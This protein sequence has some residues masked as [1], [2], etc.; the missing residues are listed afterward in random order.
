MA[1][2]PNMQNCTNLIGVPGCL[3]GTNERR[4]ALNKEIQ[5]DELIKME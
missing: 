4:H 1:G 2:K 3:E 5:T